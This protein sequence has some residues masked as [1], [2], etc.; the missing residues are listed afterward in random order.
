VELEEA[1]SRR[2]PSNADGAA[3]DLDWLAVTLAVR[4]VGACA[5]AE[6]EIT[7]ERRTHKNRDERAFTLNLLEGDT[8]RVFPTEP[9]WTG[10]VGNPHYVATFQGMAR[11]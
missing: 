11:L 10:I 1:V 5:V 7:P 9:I 3:S 2:E 6:T 4:V 8:R